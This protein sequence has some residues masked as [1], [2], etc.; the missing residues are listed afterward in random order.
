MN[1]LASIL[2]VFFGIFCKNFPKPLKNY[3]VFKYQWVVSSFAVIILNV[4]AGL[5]SIIDSPRPVLSDMIIKRLFALAFF[6]KA[7]GY[8]LFFSVIDG[9]RI[10]EKRYSEKAAWL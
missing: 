9:W 7:M 2:E 10:H 4:F 6:S 8:S 5:L 1:E 3:M